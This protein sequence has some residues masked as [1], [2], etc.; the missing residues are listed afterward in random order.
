MVGWECIKCLEDNDE[1]SELC[2]FCDTARDVADAA[3]LLKAREA[4]PPASSACTEPTGHA[5]GG[6]EPTQPATA[7][8]VNPES[9]VPPAA[10]PAAANATQRA[11]AMHRNGANES[12]RPDV[13]QA[14]QAERLHQELDELEEEAAKLWALERRRSLLAE[15]DVIDAMGSTD[16]RARLRALQLEL[17]PDKHQRTHRSHAQ[18]LFLLVQSRWEEDERNRR[19]RCEAQMAARAE[20]EAQ[21]RREE[22]AAERR[23]K[24]QAAKEEALRKEA[25]KHK[26]EQA[27]RAKQA[28]KELN[29]MRRRRSAADVDDDR[30][31]ADGEEEGQDDESEDDTGEITSEAV[32]AEQTRIEYSRKLQMATI[33]R[34]QRLLYKDE[35]APDIRVNVS[36][37]QRPIC[38]IEATESWLIADI[39]DFV[40]DREQWPAN[41]QRLLLGDR[42]VDDLEVLGDLAGVGELNFIMVV[43][44]NK[45]YNFDD[46]IVAFK[47]TW[48]VLQF[49]APALRANALTVRLALR[50]DARAIQFASPEL[51]ADRKLAKLALKTDGLALEVLPA[52]FK[53]DRRMVLRAV[54]QNWRALSVASAKMRADQEIAL[55]AVKQNTE[56]LDLVAQELFGDREFMHVAVRLEGLALRN[57][58][59]EIQ[60]DR[61]LVL[62]AVKQNPKAIMYSAQ[63]LRKDPLLHAAL[64]NNGE[65]L[66]YLQFDSGQR[67]QTEQSMFDNQFTDFTPLY[68]EDQIFAKLRGLRR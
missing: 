68:T 32:S 49:A 48:R 29:E 63:E 15:L 14:D 11:G 6:Y 4:R 1:E 55:E 62:A 61:D 31:E 35:E 41:R 57:A 17:H 46:F 39:K 28:E 42:D 2:E 22:D 3:R 36:D 10:G 5:R 33:R 20:A 43:C 47:T 40:A 26:R 53:E 52:H 19:R 18:E 16:R 59:K 25:E 8:A 38:T 66:K 13:M 60:A 37:I 27:V 67:R 12:T 45:Y 34:E 30:Q 58:S 56:A 65:M 7:P 44:P 64:K 9:A 51:R 54:R 50:K 24:A 23:K 21:R